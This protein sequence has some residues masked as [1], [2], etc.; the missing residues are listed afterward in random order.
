M[1]NRILANEETILFPYVVFLER[2]SVNVKGKPHGCFDSIASPIAMMTQEQDAAE[3]LLADIRPLCRNFATSADACPTY[4]AF[5]D[6]LSDIEQDLHQHI[7]LENNVPFPR[8]LETGGIRLP[9][10]MTPRNRRRHLSRSQV[11]A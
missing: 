8:A 11:V 5:Y 3:A 7:H 6:G 1:G 4:H 9:V 2:A 10:S